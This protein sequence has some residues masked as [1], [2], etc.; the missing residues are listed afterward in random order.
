MLIVSVI[1]V[2]ITAGSAQAADVVRNIVFPTDRTITFIDD[3]GNARSGHSHEGIDMMGEKMTPLYAAVDGRVSYIVIPEASWG[4]AVVLRDSDGYTYHYLHIN[5]DTPGTDD[6]NG[7]TQYAYAPGISR[8]TSVTKGQLIGWMGDSGNAE[9]IASH[10]HFEIRLD[11]TAINPFP[12]LTAAMSEQAQG[13]VNYDVEIATNAS[14]TINKDKKLV[15]DGGSAPCISG[16]LVKSPQTSAV[17]YCGADGKRYVFPNSRI[18]F[19][20]YDDFDEVIEITV[21]E[22]AAIPLGGNVTYK[23][24]SKMIKIESL[25]NVYAVEQ[26]G[27][28]RWVKS[29]SVAGILYGDEWAKNVD[30]LSDA[31]FG[32][33]SIGQPID[34]VS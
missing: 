2:T 8:G 31:F 4:Y 9:T 26:G 1:L 6:G 21:E 7:G 29:P 27:V 14:P 17:Y 12:S 11:G 13:N 22:L 3:F 24:G 19:T 28:L 20:W 33:Y 25:P 16:T 10:L 30:D 18:Y 15:N 23:P 5:N 32:N 34:Y